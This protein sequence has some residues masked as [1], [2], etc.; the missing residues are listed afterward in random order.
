MNPPETVQCSAHPSEDALLG[1]W[2]MRLFWMPRRASTLEL[3]PL[4]VRVGPSGLW[5][6]RGAEWYMYLRL[7]WGIKH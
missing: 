4:S 1:F 3:S 6:I 7:D 5:I 2:S